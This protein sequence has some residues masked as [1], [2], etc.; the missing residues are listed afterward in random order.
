MAVLFLILIIPLI[1]CIPFRKGHF[2]ALRLNNVW[3]WCFFA[4]AF[5][6]LK[7]EWRFKLDKKQQY[8]LCA[9]HF[10]YLDIP[11]LGLFPKPFKFVGKSQLSKVPVFGFMYNNLH[12]TVNRASVRSRG[13]TLK[14]ARA[15]LEN[16]FNLGFFPEG[17]IRVKE[18]PHMVDFQDGA[19]RL[20]A[21]NNLAI[22]PITFLDN[23]NIFF[24][25]EVFNMSRRKCRIVYHEPIRAKD[26]SEEEIKKLKTAVHRVIQ[27][28]LNA[29]H[30]SPKTETSA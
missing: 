3:A 18:F 6:P 8:I 5:L 24:D 23:Y 2:L 1:L 13:M 28:E 25:N 11:S 20:A 19:F 14:K 21:E 12:I 22:V 30:L 16:G 26:A 10:S 17:G 4:I 7:R 29:H 9:N 27:D 15:A